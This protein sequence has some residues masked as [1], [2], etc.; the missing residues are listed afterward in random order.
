MRVA[1]HRTANGYVVQVGETLHKRNRLV[2]EI[3]AAE[4]IPTL[5]V[6]GAAIALALLGIAQG[7]HPLEELRSELIRRGPRDLHPLGS[8][9]API[10]VAPVV[11][12]FNRLLGEVRDASTMQQR[13][14]ANAAHQL[15]TP[16]A[17]LQMHLELL[18]RRD[19]S[20]DVRPEL[21]RMH[22]ATVRASR[23]ANQLLA[24]AKAE[25]SLDVPHELARVDL[26][27]IASEAASD[28]VPQARAR[29]IDLGFA[30]ER[31]EIDGDPLLLS[32]LIDNLLDN[33]VR[34]TP[35]GGSVTVR[36]GCTDGA[37]FLSVEDNGPGIPVSERSRVL[38]RFYRIPGTSGDGSG[39]G[40]AIVQEVVARHDGVLEIDA[41]GD[42]G[43]AR[44][45]VRFPGARAVAV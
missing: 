45:S 12:A 31:A 17:G 15:R 14:L 1:A 21:E 24:L 38:E 10:E 16:L 7:L 30:L 39:L 8:A 18:L 11:G 22:G 41:A 36:S 28:W 35:R 20:R 26:R 40:L 6:A 25:S 42:Q 9:A 44:F 43:G 5:L 23:L 33:A 13:F 27:T 3:V 2:G 32:E 19:V 4:L 37:P 34:Y 29:D